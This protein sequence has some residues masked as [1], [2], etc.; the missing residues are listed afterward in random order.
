MSI[1]FAYEHENVT[2]VRETLLYRNWNIRVLVVTSFSGS[3]IGTVT[4]TAIN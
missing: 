4:I 1:E 3:T 2:I